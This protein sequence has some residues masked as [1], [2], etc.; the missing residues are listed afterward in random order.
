MLF[1]HLSRKSKCVPVLNDC[2]PQDVLDV[3]IPHFSKT[4]VCDHC[5]ASFVKRAFFIKHMVVCTKKHT[6]DTEASNGADS[7]INSTNTAVNDANSND[8]D[9][10]DISEFPMQQQMTAAAILS[11]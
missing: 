2:N 3:L 9:T 7:N 4:Y 5:Q 6:V 10:Y 11:C 8:T 1:R